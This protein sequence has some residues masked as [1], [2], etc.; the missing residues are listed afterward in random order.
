[1]PITPWIYRP[2]GPTDIIDGMN[3]RRC[4]ILAA[5]LACLTTPLLAQEASPAQPAFAPVD[6][7]FGDLDPLMTS[8][9]RVEIGL[10]DNGEQTSLFQ[11]D[12]Y[13]ETVDS[14]GQPIYYRLGPGF[15]ARVNRLDYVVIANP[16]PVR[17]IRQSD[18]GVN[19]AGLDGLFVEF[20]TA[21]TVYDLRPIVL[22][23]AD[24]R[25]N[26]SP[27]ADQ[28]PAIQQPDPRLDTRID[29]RVRYGYNPTL[30]PDI[31]RTGLIDALHD[32]NA[33]LRQV[34]PAENRTMYGPRPVLRRPTTPPVQPPDKQKEVEPQRDDTKKS[35]PDTP[36]NQPAPPTESK[37]PARP[38]ATARS[39]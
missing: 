31:Q 2:R 3:G 35:D 22:R 33:R 27:L 20:P 6:Q 37:A 26:L 14:T 19:V 34:W 17:K 36:A 18:L 39:E 12:P 16:F 38:D 8:L 23:D 11:L 1:M 10:N 28:P 29:P 5:T 25:L 13:G 32:P 15:R 9:R 7:A 24:G 21:N 4:T 30:E